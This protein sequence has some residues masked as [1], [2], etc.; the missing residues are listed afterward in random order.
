MPLESITVDQAK[1]ASLKGLAVIDCDVHNW[2]GENLLPF[3]SERWRRYHSLVGERISGLGLRGVKSPLRPFTARLDAIP[4]GG[5]PP[6]S[7]PTFAREQLLDAHGIRAAIINNMECLRGGNA[8]VAMEI[9]LARAMNDYTEEWW[10]ESDPRWLSSIVVAS[11]HPDEAVKEIARCREKS[12]RFV[13]VLMNTA[14]ERPQGNPK[15]WPI[16]EAAEH[17]GIPV[18]FHTAGNNYQSTTGSGEATFYFELRTSIAMAAQAMVP[19]LIFEGVFERFPTLK[20]VPVE[21]GWTW[22]VP[23]AWRLD[24]TWRVMRDEVAHLEREPAS[25]LRDHFWFSTQPAVEP[26]R[27]AQHLALHEQLE[28]EGLGDRLMFSTDYPHWDMD[29]PLDALPRQLARLSKQKILAGNAAALYG[30]AMDPVA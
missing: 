2:A 24:S 22:V 9:D 29:A 4:P 27:P 5:G 11:D 6:G 10:L 7:D 1:P 21:V 28:R 18:A 20:V 23:L 30:L 3:L 13:Q 26:A 14:T 17:H 19:S 15:Y 8:P 25:Y 16:Y 12:D